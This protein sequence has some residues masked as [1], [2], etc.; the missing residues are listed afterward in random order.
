M[1]VWLNVDS[2][3]VAVNGYSLLGLQHIPTIMA[4][5][6][7]NNPDG[8][9]YVWI[10]SK[11]IIFLL[12]YSVAQRS[13]DEKCESSVIS[14]HFDWKKSIKVNQWWII[15]GLDFYSIGLKS[16]YPCSDKNSKWGEFFNIGFKLTAT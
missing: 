9:Q 3:M 7:F 8:R 13:N 10:W 5:K 16:M 4:G 12:F 15:Q 2:F 6:C 1:Y 11:C 14:S